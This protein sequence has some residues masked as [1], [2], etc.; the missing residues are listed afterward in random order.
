MTDVEMRFWSKVR[1]GDG[2]WEWTADTGGNRRADGKK[3]GY[4][5]VGGKMRRAHRVAWEMERG[6]IPPGLHVLH[7]CDNPA[8]VRPGHLWVGT[9]RQNMDDRSAKGRIPR[10]VALR[11]TQ[12]HAAKLDESK[13]QEIRARAATGETHTAIAASFGVTRPT[14]SDVIQGRAWTHVPGCAHPQPRQGRRR[15][16]RRACRGA[17]SGTG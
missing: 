3:Y 12:H 1:V 2:C 4:F 17:S 10:G 15:A 5:C 8:C 16:A 13:V 7:S 9:H 6:P 11:G 14:V